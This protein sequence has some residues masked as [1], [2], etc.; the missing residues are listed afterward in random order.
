MESTTISD[1]QKQKYQG[2][3]I[4]LHNENGINIVQID[5]HELRN[6][7]EYKIESIS[8]GITEITLKIKA[9][10]IA[11]DFEMIAEKPPEEH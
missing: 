4:L 11:S 1:E 8:S 2:N 10:L 9:R 5:G 6:V 3:E 7:A